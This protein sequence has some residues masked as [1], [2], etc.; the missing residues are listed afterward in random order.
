VTT[1]V[2]IILVA[3]GGFVVG[4]AWVLLRWERVE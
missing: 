1:P 2:D 3:I 4:A